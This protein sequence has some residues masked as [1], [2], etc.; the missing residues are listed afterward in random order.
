MF[1][2]TYHL[3]RITYFWGGGGCLILRDNHLIIIIII[4]IIISLFIITLQVSHHHRHHNIRLLDHQLIRPIQSSNPIH[5]LIHPTVHRVV[6]YLWSAF[7]VIFTPLTYLPT[8]VAPH[9]S[10]QG[11]NSI[12]IIQSS[13]EIC[14]YVSIPRFHLVETDGSWYSSLISQLKDRL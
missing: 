8:F 7:Q 10:S 14:M 13:Y 9:F 12:A 3:E 4:V 5:S 6:V 2:L 1:Y 11:H